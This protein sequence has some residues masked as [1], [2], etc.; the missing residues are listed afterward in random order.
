MYINGN[1]ADAGL[2]DDLGWFKS[3]RSGGN[4][5]AC[6]EVAVTGDVVGVRDSKQV[7]GGRHTGPR[8]PFDRGAW[9]AFVADVKSGLH[10]L[11]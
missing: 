9:G 8:L 10:D 1:P 4:G 5:G 11:T 6:V 3:S 7:A 2:T